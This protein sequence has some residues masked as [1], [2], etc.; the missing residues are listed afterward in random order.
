V[1]NVGASTARGVRV[2]FKNR[3]SAVTYPKPTARIGAL[4][5]GAAET[6]TLRARIRTGA[7]TKFILKALSDNARRTTAVVRLGGR[8]S[9]RP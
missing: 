7:R 8:P 4:R 6:M 5:A 9:T 2:I 1:T 3:P